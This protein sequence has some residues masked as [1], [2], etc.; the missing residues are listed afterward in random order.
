MAPR[1]PNAVPRL[2]ILQ[3]AESVAAADKDLHREEGL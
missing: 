3:R 1:E 2:W